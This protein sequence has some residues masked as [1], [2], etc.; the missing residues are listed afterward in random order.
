MTNQ[1][2][3]TIALHLTDIDA[4]FYNIET[5]GESVSGFFESA[6]VQAIPFCVDAKQFLQAAVSTRYIIDYEKTHRGMTAWLQS[7]NQQD[8]AFPLTA[9]DYICDCVERDAKDLQEIL[10]DAIRTQFEEYLVKLA[11]EVG[12]TCTGKSFVQRMRRNEL[13]EDFYRAV[14]NLAAIVQEVQKKEAA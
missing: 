8:D 2:L 7:I 13:G 1:D 9:S 12:Y 4:F 5:G 14:L 11:G 10:A 3:A 6:K